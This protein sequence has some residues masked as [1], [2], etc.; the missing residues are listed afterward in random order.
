GLLVTVDIPAS[1][2]S[3]HVT[4]RVRVPHRVLRGLGEERRK[5]KFP[6]RLQQEGGRRL[7]IGKGGFAH[8]Y[9]LEAATQAHIVLGPE[10]L[11]AH[12]VQVLDNTGS[13][14]LPFVYTM[15]RSPDVD[16]WLKLDKLLEATLTNERAYLFM[17]ARDTISAATR[18]NIVGPLGASVLQHQVAQI[19]ENLLKKW[20][21]H[22]S[23]VVNNLRSADATA[24]VPAAATAAAALGAVTGSAAAAHEAGPK[25]EE[26][27]TART[28]ST[29]SQYNPGVLA[30]H[31]VE[32]QTEPSPQ[33]IES[34]LIPELPE[35]EVAAEQ[36]H[37]VRPV[38]K[39]ASAEVAER[40][41]PP[42]KSPAQPLPL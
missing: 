9:G 34:C 41:Q 18:L 32:Q 22:L 25:T 6:A 1:K 24:R 4:V 2:F 17:T 8:S 7:L 37:Y 5:K 39:A 23:M 38:A 30:H 31:G 36:Y 13:L 35:V 28:P 16:T 21:N 3:K 40:L 42:D 14:L 33:E 29:P 11:K 12:V 10:D 19:A 15:N 27:E 26:A 20:M